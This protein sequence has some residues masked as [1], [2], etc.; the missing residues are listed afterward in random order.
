MSSK[1]VAKAAQAGSRV[2]A[3]NKVS[4][5]QVLNDYSVHHFGPKP[6]L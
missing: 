3:V 2:I 6:V 4:S 1:A 5:I